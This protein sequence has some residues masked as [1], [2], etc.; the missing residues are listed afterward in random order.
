MVRDTRSAFVD[1]AT[2]LF[3]EKGFYG[4]S[5]ATIADELG[6]TKQALLHHFG[7]KQ[8]L[9]GEVLQ[10]TADRMVRLLHS[11]MD[12]SADPVQQL[13]NFFRAAFQGASTDPSD[14]QLLMRELLD[15]E[16]R[17]ESAAVWYLKPFLS[18]LTDVVVSIPGQS[19]D[20]TAALAAVYA[21]LGALNYFAISGPTLRQMYGDHS[22]EQLEH[23]YDLQL[24]AFLA[25]RFT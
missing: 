11:A 3:S 13:Q 1:T 23:E 17:A 5:L 20:R 25:A 24:Q 8:K 22:Y 7:S 18:S 2:A 12:S 10:A 6:L 14:T 21:M 15:N 19:T 4:V 16:R 9:Y